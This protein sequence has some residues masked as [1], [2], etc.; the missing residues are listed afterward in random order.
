MNTHN[1]VWRDDH[2]PVSTHFDD[3]YF[4]DDGAIAET[5]YVFIEG[6]QL[7]Q[8]FLAHTQQVFTIGE[9]G[10]GSGLNFL[11]T[12]QQFLQ[13][14]QQYPDHVLKKLQFFSIEKYP[15]LTEELQTIHQKIVIDSH[16]YALAKQLQN[17]W[18]TQKV[19]FDDNVKLDV[20][21]ADITLF[22]KHL[23][24]NNILIDAWFFDGFS[25]AKNPDMWSK[26]LFTELYQLTNPFGTFATFTAAG[27]VRRNLLA[28]GFNVSKRQG[29]GKKREMLIGNKII[30]SNNQ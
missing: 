25:P 8:R 23:L 28:A 11:M 10:F 12:W 15:L 29:Y 1:I 14:R 13:F 26:S 21:V 27:A 9:T 7:K 19:L 17:S 22:S 20:L 6:N 18:P 24:V 3:V 16:L 4:N 30:L 2:T 5:M